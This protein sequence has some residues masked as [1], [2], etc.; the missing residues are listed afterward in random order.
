MLV[1][2]NHIELDLNVNG[3]I[4]QIEYDLMDVEIGEFGQFQ[5]QQSMVQGQGHFVTLIGALQMN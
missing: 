5:L 1:G 3:T 2:G 4:R